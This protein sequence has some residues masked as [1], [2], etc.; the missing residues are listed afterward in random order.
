MLPLVIFAVATAV[1]VYVLFGYPLLLGWLAKVQ[2]RPIQKKPQEPSISVIVAVYNGEQYLDAKL[3]SILALEY[4]RDRMEVLIASDGST[5]RTAAIAASY[6]AQG[7]RL[8]QLPRGGKP[9]AL[10]AAI[11]QSRGEILVLTDVRQALA[12]D[13][14]RLLVACFAD[15]TVGVVSGELRIRSGA[16][17]D[18]DSIGLYWRFETWIRDRLSTIDSMFGATGPFYGIRRELAQPVPVDVL[19]DDM[20]LPLSAFFKG[21]RL[22][23]EPRAKAFDYPMSLDTEFR[24]KVRT[25][26][27]NYQLLKYYPQLLGPSNRMWLHYVSYKLGRLL[28]P[29]ALMAILV[30]SFFL[31]EPVRGPLLAAQVL[32]YGAA[33]LDRFVPE[34]SSVKRLTSPVR[35][36]VTIMIAA[37]AGLSVFFVQPQRLWKVTGASDAK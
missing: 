34:G 16:H 11:P 30:T 18:E 3:Q 36:F 28:L 33:L 6:A 1:L 35:T 24:R 17:Q 25:L 20:F 2:A 14:V 15:P 5:D 37:V 9:A 27:G 8:L 32:F 12:P 13:S 31:P 4:P 23:M 21:Y 10:N 22:V 29:W 26:A 7:V 19:L